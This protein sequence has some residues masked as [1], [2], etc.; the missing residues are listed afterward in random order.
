MNQECLCKKCNKP[1]PSDRDS[2][3]CSA[4]CSEGHDETT[5]ISDVV[6]KPDA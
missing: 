2:A 5:L 1:I 3:F 6:E 4:E